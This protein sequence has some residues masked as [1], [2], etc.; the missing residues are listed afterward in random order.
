MKKPKHI[1][2][3][4]FNYLLIMFYIIKFVLDCKI[5]YSLLK[6]LV[7]VNLFGAGIIFL[8][9]STSCI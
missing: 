7:F 4:I 6:K 9:F 3:M 5:I 8:N 1:A 2:V